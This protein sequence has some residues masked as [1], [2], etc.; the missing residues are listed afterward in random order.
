MVITLKANGDPRRTVDYQQLNKATHREI[1]HTP[2]P[3]NLVASI[4]GNTLKTVL[5]AWNGY[6]SLLLDEDS[7]HLTTFITEWGAYRYC[8]GP[9][10]YHGTGDAFICRFDDITM[11][12]ERYVRCIDDGLLYDND[13]ESAFWHTF[14]HLKLCAENGII[15]NKEKFKFARDTVEF[16][17]F[18]VTPRGY[19][20]AKRIIQAICNFPTPT[21]IT[22]V[23]SWLGLVQHVAYTFS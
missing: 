13:L 2:S 19:R 1:H 9:Q 23:K 21:S 22:D 12:E 18:D 5:D 14:D 20:P 8:R 15:F 11:N 7:R 3:I 4:P 16:A 10:G 17:G 6:H